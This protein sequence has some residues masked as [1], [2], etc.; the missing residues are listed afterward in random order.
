M[1]PDL[2]IP[3]PTSVPARRRRIK[4]ELVRIGKGYSFYAIPPSWRDPAGSGAGGGSCMNRRDTP[5]YKSGVIKV[6]E[7]SRR[8]H[9]FERGRSAGGVGSADK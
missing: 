4:E 7:D 3:L 1:I 6:L 2:G 9:D 8:C 5:V